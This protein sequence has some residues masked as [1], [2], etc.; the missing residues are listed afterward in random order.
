MTGIDRDEAA[1]ICGSWSHGELVAIAE[2]I[3]E[4]LW[5]TDPRRA[6]ALVELGQRL[7][8]ADP[9]LRTDPSRL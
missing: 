5:D 3:A 8:A 6:A 9:H 1:G 2:Y 4:G 7:F